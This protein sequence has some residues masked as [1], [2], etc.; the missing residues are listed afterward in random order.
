MGKVVYSIV[1]PLYNEEEVIAETY[2]RLKSVA[3]NFDAPYEIILINDGSRDKTVPMA[4][5]ICEKDKTVKLIDF[6]RNFGHQ[7]AV[8]AGM[9]YAAGDAVIVIDADL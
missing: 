8:T 5:A 9:D 3:E 7:I 6:S 1:V 4:H 2:K